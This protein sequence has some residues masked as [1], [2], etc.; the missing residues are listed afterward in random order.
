MVRLKEEG[1][2][3]D[4]TIKVVISRAE[5]T[6][7]IRDEIWQLKAL[8]GN[9]APWVVTNKPRGYGPSNIWE[10][11][12][13]N[14][15]KQISKPAAENLEREKGIRTV[16]DLKKFQHATKREVIVIKVDNVSVAK[17]TKAIQVACSSEIKPGPRPMIEKIDHR[18]HEN[19][20]LSLHGDKWEYKIKTC[21]GLKN[22]CASMI[23]CTIF[24][25]KVKRFSREQKVR[26]RGFFTTMH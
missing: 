26:K 20:Y 3:I 14:K 21:T 11:N 7:R 13:L 16:S 5:E 9:Q 23:L 10:D 19:P 22:Q 12:P 17:L 15:L 24:T 25:W 2:M 6:K 4:Y 8:T 18:H 1:V